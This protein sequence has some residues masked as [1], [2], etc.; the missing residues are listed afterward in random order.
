MAQHNLL[1]T[2]LPGTGKTTLIARLIQ[3]L[4]GVRTAGFYTE[5]LRVG[6][7]RKGFEIVDFRGERLLLSHVDIRGGQRVGRYGVD[8]ARFERYLESVPFL[9]A[10]TDLVIIDEIGKMECL[11]AKF[12][13]LVVDLLD[14][15]VMMVATIAFYGGGIIQDIKDRA[16]VRLYRVTKDN[17]DSLAGEI[18]KDVREGLAQRT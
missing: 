5:E 15:P 14:A 9:S 3:R 2:G 6:G 12:R 18:E 17:R 16:D 7:V 8:V 4:E 10:H 1:V 11:S 13:Y